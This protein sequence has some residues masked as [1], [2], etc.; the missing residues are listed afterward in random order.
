MC[1]RDSCNFLRLPGVLPIPGPPAAPRGG[2]PAH[3]GGA[4]LGG[5]GGGG[6]PRGEQR[7]YGGGSPAG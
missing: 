3:A 4:F 1:I 5:S 2:S 7:G 6:S